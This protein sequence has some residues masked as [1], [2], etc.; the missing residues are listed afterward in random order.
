[1][2]LARRMS[3][4]AFLVRTGVAAA[5]ATAGR[6]MVGAAPAGAQPLDDLLDGVLPGLDP[7]LQALAVDAFAGLGAFVVPSTDPYSVAQGLTDDRPGAIA[8]ENPRFMLDALDKKFLPI[9]D[10]AARALAEAFLANA[11]AL[12]LPDELLDLLP[13]GADQLDE[14]LLGLLENDHVVPTG[15]VLAMY[16]DLAATLVDPGAVVGSFTAPFANLSWAQK[17]AALAMIEE[18][19]AELV[20]ALDDGL[21]Q[22]LEDSVSGLI[23][24]AIGALLEFVAFGS[25]SEFHQLD[26]A[27][28]PLRLRG[29]PVG[30]ELTGY[31]PGMVER[32]HGWDELIGYHNGVPAVSGSWDAGEGILGRA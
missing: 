32:G 6:G 18:Q 16:L 14:L 9:P 28:D 15:L 19:Q 4:R 3:R 26:R 8:A 11:T 13:V 30:W 23:R 1:M 21:P 5:V 22:P 24:F 27:A 20:N 17:G 2:A 25:Y 10:T 29:R 31:Q 7:V 12:P